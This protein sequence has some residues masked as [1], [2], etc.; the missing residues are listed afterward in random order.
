[1][2]TGERTPDR[3]RTWWAVRRLRLDDLEPDV[4]RLA[5]G[6][7]TVAGIS[8]TVILAWGLGWDPPGGRQFTFFGP[9]PPRFLIPFACAAFGA[10]AV[11]AIRSTAVRAWRAGWVVRLAVGLAGAAVAGSTVSAGWSVEEVGGPGTAGLRALA[12]VAFGVAL[13]TAALPGGVMS[14]RPTLAGLMGAAPFALVALAWGMGGSAPRVP[15]GPLV[16]VPVRDVLAQGV[17]TVVGAV[18]A[19][20]G[21][22]LIWGL[23]LSGRQARDMGQ[24]VAAVGRHLAWLLPAVLALKVGAVILAYLEAVP[25]DSDGFESSRTDGLVGWGVALLLGF[26]AWRW[27]L[28]PTR[29]APSA[30]K[31]E[32]VVRPVGFGFVSVLLTAAVLGLAASA[33]LVL[34]TTT[35]VRALTDAIDWLAVSFDPPVPLWAVVVTTAVVV[36]VAIARR[37]RPGW[38]VVAAA[39]AVWMAPRAIHL[40]YQIVTERPAWFE[41]PSLTTMDTLVTAL[42]ALLALGWWSGRQRRVEPW[43]LLLVLV[44]STLVAHPGSLLPSDWKAGFLFHLLLVYAPAYRF[45]FDAETI[46]TSDDRA[47]KVVRTTLLAATLLAVTAMLVLLGTVV[48]GA[49]NPEQAVIRAIGETYLV[50]PVAA[51]AVAAVIADGSP[52]P[53]DAVGNRMR[54]WKRI[55]ALVGRRRSP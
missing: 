9:T 42:M 20:V 41:P 27:L 40:G 11:V 13:L 4:R 49:G 30:A 54:M 12:W 28:A 37:R 16:S 23:A 18:A 29:R 7:L 17:I 51:L 53:D 48:P 14:G 26:L 25:W 3:L 8:A 5:I 39:L 15:V 35:P 2:T 1:V 24:G 32:A 43:A 50:L 47:G 31:V 55:A 45:L 6:A 46:N 33:L 10:L 21:V 36:A 38:P 34:P 44:A 52:L 19:A 22:V